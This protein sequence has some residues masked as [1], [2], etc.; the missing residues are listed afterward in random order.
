MSEVIET[1]GELL[2]IA[3]DRLAHTEIK[4]LDQA[5]AIDLVRTALTGLPGLLQGGIVG[6]ILQAMKPVFDIRLGDVLATVWNTRRDLVKFR[7]RNKYPP[8]ELEELVLGK[9]RVERT[10][11]PRIE[12][13]VDDQ[14][15]AEVEFEIE[16]ELT[17]ET[18]MLQIRDAKILGARTG[19][20]EG[21]ATLK[22]GKAI[23]P[24]PKP[25]KFNLPGTL[26]FKEPIA[27]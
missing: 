26:T 27:I 2:G 17:I 18:V 20:C 22:C 3:E 9:Q 10:L 23:L 6:D 7:D 14:K 12:I 25:R 15:R 13:L 19:S 24:S 11:K 21:K 1:L 4:W 8:D 16:L 5:Q